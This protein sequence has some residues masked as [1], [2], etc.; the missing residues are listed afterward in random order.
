MGTINPSRGVTRYIP[1]FIATTSRSINDIFSLIM[2][3]RVTPRDTNPPIP[4]VAARQWR[5]SPCRLS[6][7]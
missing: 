2:M 3:S 6:N 1:L 7:N 5:V 4:R